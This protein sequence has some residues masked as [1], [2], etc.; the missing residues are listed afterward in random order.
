M[1]FSGVVA[2]ATELSQSDNEVLCADISSLGGQRRSVLNRDVTHLFA[3]TT[4]STKY[5]IAMYYK[6]S[7]IMKVVTPHWF[8]DVVRLGT[9]GLPTTEYE[10]PDPPIFRNFG[11]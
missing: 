5:E 9:R 4:G 7:T 11:A 1:L 10:F 8:D 6:D 3:M 2:T